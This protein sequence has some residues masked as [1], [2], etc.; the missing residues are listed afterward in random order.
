MTTGQ[1]VKL[2][3]FS[4][5][6][7]GVSCF[8]SWPAV[9]GPGVEV[10][11]VRLPGRETRLR[12]P[13][14][15]TCAELREDLLGRL[16]EAAYQ[17]PY[18]LYGH[19]LGALVAYVLTRA[20]AETGAPP[21]LFLAVGACMPPDTTTPLLGAAEL[22]DEEL[23]VHLADLGS[24]PKGAGA[25]PG[26]LWRRAVLPVLRDDLR[27]AARLREAAVDPLAGGPV[28]VPL[29]VFSGSEDPVAPPAPL[30]GWRHWTTGPFARHTVAGDH[31]FV[32]GGELPRLVG[33]VCREYDLRAAVPGLR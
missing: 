22:S 9:A 32:R 4:H 16:A 12:Q 21:P 10:V 19:S 20:L 25:A 24:L 6:G 17:G 13:R 5:A 2:H 14:L 31:F 28:D 3:C 30:D 23:F 15:T 29:V 1:P 33:D 26:G 18:A 8:N 27:L 11:P 7:A